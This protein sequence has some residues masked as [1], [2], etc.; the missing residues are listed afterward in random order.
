MD[1]LGGL[2]DAVEIAAK[3]AKLS[4]YRISELPETKKAFEQIVEEL[5]ED[6]EA[7]WMK[8]KLGENY[9]IYNSYQSVMKLQGIQARSF[10]DFQLY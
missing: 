4:N 2:D 1:V 6:M 3:K 10:V 8:N 5:S 7:R 9:Y